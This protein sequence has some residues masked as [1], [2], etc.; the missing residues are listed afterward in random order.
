MR[1]TPNRARTPGTT[2]NSCFPAVAGSVARPAFTLMEMV[3]VVAI[4]GLLLAIAVPASVGLVNSQKAKATKATM[5]TLE[6][7]INSFASEK[8]ISD[9]WYV[10]RYG[11]F[12]PSPATSVVLLASDPAF[13]K[14]GPTGSTN[15]EYRFAA[16]PGTKSK[17]EALVRGYLVPPGNVSTWHYNDNSSWYET[18]Y[19]DTDRYLDIET[20]VLFLRQ[21]SPQ[22]RQSLDRMQKNTTNKDGDRIAWDADGDNSTPEVKTT[23]LFEVND[24]WGNALRYTVQSPVVN[25]KGMALKIRWELRSAGPDGKFSSTFL[26]LP[27]PDGA[28]ANEELAGD[29]VVL[30]GP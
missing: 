1:Y 16:D 20:L 21:L 25:S 12:P 27:G 30:R 24:A 8:P 5:Q 3:V 17:F 2:G 11:S 19:P 29:D 28:F 14:A 13:S 18:D 26:A 15:G 6:L 22:A 4:I 7:A 9:D 23:D 10:A